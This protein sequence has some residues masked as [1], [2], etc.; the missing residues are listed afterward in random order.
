MIRGEG[1]YL[2]DHRG[3]PYL[4]LVN[5]VCHVGHCHPRVVAAGQQQMARLNTNTRY[6]YDGLTEYAEQLC[7]T[8]P[9]PLDTCFFV[10]SGSEANELAIRLA[11]TYTGRRDFVVLEGA[12]HGNTST[13]IEISPY[14]F[15]GNGGI[16]FH[17]THDRG[18]DGGAP[19]FSVNLTPTVGW[20]IHT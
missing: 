20:A 16:I 5:N 4:D 1:Q 7:A 18:G 11:K 3:Q 17:G 14:K 15:M 9:D 10:N 19:T 2:F 6:L 13:L 12:Y 8:L